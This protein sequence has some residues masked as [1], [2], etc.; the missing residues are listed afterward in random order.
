MTKCG[1]LR[2]AG[3][4]WQL[5][6]EIQVATRDAPP[7]ISALIEREVVR[8]PDFERHVLEAASVAGAEFP[9]AALA[10]ALGVDQ[11]AVEET[12]LRWS[13]SGRF[14]RQHAT[15]D[16]SEGLRC[17]FIHSLYQQVIGERIAP[18]RRVQLH[19]RIGAW[20]EKSHAENLQAVAAEL[21]MHFERAADFGRAISYRQLAGEQALQRCAYQEAIHHLQAAQ[22]LMRRLPE[23]SERQRVELGLLLAVGIPVAMTRGYTSP[24][25][26]GV[27]LRAR[28]LCRDL[29]DGQR[30]HRVLIGLAASYAVRGMFGQAHELAGH[31]VDLAR[32]EGDAALRQE[33]NLA[34]LFSSFHLGEF[35]NIRELVACA[36]EHYG[37]GQNGSIASSILQ[38]LRTTTSFVIASPL[39]V[40]GHADQ[41]RHWAD[42]GVALATER[43]DH[44][45][46]SQCLAY[47]M[48]VDILRGDRELLRTKAERCNQ[49]CTEHGFP[50]FRITATMVLGFLRIEDGDATT[51]IA[52]M[53]EAWDAR[54]AAGMFTNATFWY[55]VGANACARAGRMDLA[56]VMLADAFQVVRSRGERCWEPELHRVV[57][58]FSMQA[59]ASGGTLIAKSLRHDETPEVAYTRALEL[60]REMGAKSL[61]LRAATSLA[62]LWRNEGRCDAARRLLESIY[63]WFTEGHDTIDHV[64]A[65]VELQALGNESARVRA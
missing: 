5:D 15:C 35:T 49:L 27:Y 64:D 20:L 33:A 58:E 34:R 39:W 28:D 62:R 14:L 11:V 7:S 2:Q 8:L 65:R 43:N 47:S 9:V 1:H 59:S 45:A 60:A 16:A 18:A 31:A 22:E 4:Y 36:V 29:G 56:R 53:Q 57:G 37:T 48:V 50:F 63:G 23:G 25:M 52:L 41:A 46:I 3:G 12:C 51:G 30:L 44:F 13:R 42:N 55:A 26:E 19:S 38:D 24:D 40:L 32:T 17:A 21:S 10:T 61:E 6:A 54:E